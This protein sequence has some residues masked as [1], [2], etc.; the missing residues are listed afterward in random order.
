VFI[1]GFLLCLGVFVVHPSPPFFEKL[2]AESGKLKAE[3]GEAE[4]STEHGAGSDSKR[5]NAES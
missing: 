4:K 2:K 1:R 5:R 3:R